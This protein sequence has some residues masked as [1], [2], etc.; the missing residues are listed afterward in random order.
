VNDQTYSYDVDSALLG[1]A[2]SKLEPGESFLEIG[3]G[4]GG[5]LL[6]AA[7]KFRLVVGTDILPLRRVDSDL[8]AKAEIIIT[9]KA[10]CFRDYVF[11]VVAFNPPY[12]PSQSIED[13]SIDGGPLGIE[14]P[15]DF[16]SS[17]LNVLK[18]KGMILVLLS[19]LGTID[20][21]LKFC[22]SHSLVADKIAE[23]RLFFETLFVYIVSRR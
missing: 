4:G 8:C 3:F 7:R 10:S 20:V 21:F 6:V 9:D 16:L 1:E 23:R 2:I 18:E 5:N 15:L 11:D 19:S 12:L 22:I 14:V 17:A 13:K